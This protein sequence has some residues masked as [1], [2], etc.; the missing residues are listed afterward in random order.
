MAQ[1]RSEVIERLSILIFDT[2]AS[3]NEYALT[4]PPKLGQ[5]QV[6][7]AE[8]QTAGRGRLGR[9]WHSPA[10]GNIYLSLSWL[11]DR[12][13]AH[14]PRLPALSLV[15]G[16]GVIEVLRTLAPQVDWRLKW[17][18]DV[19]ADGQKVA[20]I[21]LES[22]S[23][24]GQLQLVVGLGLN[25]HG[26]QWSG[27]DKAVTS[28]AVLADQ[29][30]DRAWIVARL[31]NQWAL[32]IPVFLTAGLASFQARWQAVDAL[33][34]QDVVLTTPQGQIVGTA[35][36]INATGALQLKHEDGQVRHYSVGEV[37]RLRPKR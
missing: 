23:I 26:R 36:G 16:L 7:L 2:L 4:H 27:L 18:N 21:L 15:I 1:V 31:L 32:D 24:D 17:P 10:H 28:L 12:N 8:S 20:G 14:R 35:H 33:L 25:V 5:W 37:E 30:Y 9:T 6:T 13:Y 11:L 22:H 34:G 19:W 29:D 3:T